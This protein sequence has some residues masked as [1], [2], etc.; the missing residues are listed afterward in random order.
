MTNTQRNIRRMVCGFWL[1]AAVGI[2]S[3]CTY[4]NNFAYNSNEIVVE[5]DIQIIETPA[6]ISGSVHATSKTLI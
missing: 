2:T 4:Q 5:E 3:F 1:V 6:P